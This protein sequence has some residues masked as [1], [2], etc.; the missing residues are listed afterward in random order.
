MCFISSL[1]VLVNHK[2]LK[3]FDAVRQ[4]WFL[5]SNRMEDFVNRFYDVSKLLWCVK[6]MQFY[7]K[8]DQLIKYI[9]F[10]FENYPK[11]IKMLSLWMRKV[12][13]ML[14]SLGIVF[15]ITGKLESLFSQILLTHSF[16]RHSQLPRHLQK[17]VHTRPSDNVGVKNIPSTSE[18]WSYFTLCSRAPW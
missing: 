18:W 17:T 15:L 6:N 3:L 10:R 14:T 11:T 8:L 1:L 16:F 5:M 4:Y 12:T 2:E 9:F 7:L 13:K